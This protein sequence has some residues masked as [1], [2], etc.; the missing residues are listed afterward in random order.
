MYIYIYMY[1]YIHTYTFEKNSD[2]RISFLLRIF[3]FT[4]DDVGED[5]VV[6]KY[7]RLDFIIIECADC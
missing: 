2:N 7:T 6:I 1:I 5:T 4:M 3:F